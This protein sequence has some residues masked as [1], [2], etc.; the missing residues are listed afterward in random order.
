MHQC[1]TSRVRNWTGINL[2][3]NQEINK[4]NCV[5]HFLKRFNNS[6]ILENFL[7]HS[8]DN[9]DGIVR[10]KFIYEYKS[11]ISIWGGID[12]FYGDS[13]GYFGQFKGLDRFN[14]GLKIG[15]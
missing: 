10:P 2:R 14:F 1:Y 8:L 3:K 4:Q 15:I 7:V 6:L 12:I 5:L 13:L 11:N 9:E